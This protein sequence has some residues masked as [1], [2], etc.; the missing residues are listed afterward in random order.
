MLGSLLDADGETAVVL[1]RGGA[2]DRND[3]HELRRVPTSPLIVI[4]HAP[5]GVVPPSIRDLVAMTVSWGVPGR[6]GLAA[7]WESIGGQGDLPVDIRDHASLRVRLL[8]QKMQALG[9]ATDRQENL[10]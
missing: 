8:Q 7:I 4:I 2:G 3:L 1:I 10:P 9:L 5:M 6:A